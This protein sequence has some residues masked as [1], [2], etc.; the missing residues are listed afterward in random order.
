MNLNFLHVN[1]ELLHKLLLH[2]GLWKLVM[3]VTYCNQV[4]RIKN[5]HDTSQGRCFSSF[6]SPVTWRLRRS[7][8]CLLCSQRTP[9]LSSLVRRH[10]V[11]WSYH[12]SARCVQRRGPRGRTDRVWRAGR[13]CFHHWMQRLYGKSRE[14]QIIIKKPQQDL[15]NVN[16]PEK[17]LA[18]LGP[19]YSRQAWYLVLW[20]QAGTLPFFSFFFIINGLFIQQY[21]K[22]TLA[23]KSELRS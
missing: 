8:Y 10:A 18:G 20:K 19:P 21:L 9:S 16:F 7:C 1:T 13:E 23:V 11:A 17:W 6:A 15:M 12:R 22:K 4:T 14:N 3:F 2:N 5:L